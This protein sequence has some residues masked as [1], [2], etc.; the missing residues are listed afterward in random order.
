MPELPEVEN[1]IRSLVKKVKDKKIIGVEIITPSIIY[2]RFDFIELVGNK[3]IKTL[4]R[5]GKYIIVRLDEGNL[6]I[7]L[8]MTGKLLFDGIVSKHT[9]LR[10]D[11][12][13]GNYLL[14][15]D[16]RKFG[17]ISYMSNKELEIYLATK[18]GLE[19]ALMEYTD[20]KNKLMHKGGPI[21]KNLLDQT[22]IAGIGNIYAD[23]ILYASGLHPLFETKSLLEADLSNLY[24][25]IREILEKATEA[26]GSTIRDY[27]NG[28][29]TAGEYQDAHKV[30]GR[31]GKK[32]DHCGCILEKTKVVGRTSTFCPICQ[33][34]R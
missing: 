3:T 16:V 1:V 11:L 12:M 28:N 9:H 4:E 2:N 5:R 18:V 23:E 19:P 33:R 10:F 8:R 13:D 32:C 30:Y 17:R 21:K 20:F 26:G 25:N 34:I 31:S 22:I 6:L 15:N 24:L 27:V 7:H 29:G 14:Y